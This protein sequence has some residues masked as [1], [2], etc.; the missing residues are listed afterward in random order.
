MILSTRSIFGSAIGLLL[1]VGSYPAEAFTIT[2]QTD[3]EILK[4]VLL[5]DTSGLDNFEVIAKDSSLAYGIFEN[6]P[7]NLT[8]GVV[9]STGNIKEL[10]AQ[11]LQ[12]G[13]LSK[14]GEDLSTDLGNPGSDDDSISLELKFYSDGT[15]D[16]FY[17]QYVFGSEEFVE[18][19]GEKFNDSFSLK[20]NGIPLATLSNGDAT[21][22]NNLVPDP[23]VGYHPDFIYNSTD[24]GP[25]KDQTKLD[26]YTVPLL[27]SG[28]IIP[29]AHNQL[30][31]NIHDVG[32]G[33]F[34]SAVFL[35]AGTFGTVKPPSI[36]LGDGG[37]SRNDNGNNGDNGQGDTPTSIPEPSMALGLVTVALIGRFALKIK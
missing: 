1:I 5:G 30:L 2:R 26:G 21:T 35:K 3:P 23:H 8:S 12:D 15:K 34:D 20:L 37:D 17:F 28:P 16:T 11:N 36:I 32:D 25:A 31:I 22:I 27:F 7:F 9:L 6:D 29:N 33:L 14:I 4:E 24:S 10:A 13:G 19:G 18:F